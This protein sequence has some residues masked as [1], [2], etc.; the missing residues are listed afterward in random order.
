LDDDTIRSVVDGAEEVKPQPETGTARWPD[1]LDQAALYGIAGEMVSLVA[2]HTESD[3]AALLIQLLVGAGNLFGRYR[4]F[5]VES[6]DHHL[7]LLVV[8]VGPSAKGR[9]G[10]AW[11]WIK[12]ELVEVDPSWGKR[13]QTGLSSGEG[14]IYSVR[15]AGTSN[16]NERRKEK[17]DPGVSDKRALLIQ[18]EFSAVLKVCAREGNTLSDVIRAVWDGGDLQVAT[19]NFPNTATA[20]HVSLIG[21]ISREE[22]TATF[23][24][25]D[26][27]NGFGNRFLWVC[28]KRSNILP[29]GGNLETN[30]LKPII[31]QMRQAYDFAVNNPGEMRFAPEAEA[32]W[33]RIYPDLSGDRTGL[34]GALLS[35]AEAQ[36]RR[37]AC[38][39]TALDS[40]RET[41]TEHLFAALAV[42]EY[43]ERSVAFIFR[44][45]TGNP[46]ADKILAALLKSEG[47]LT[48][49]M[50][51]KLFGGNLPA[52][53]IDQALGALHALGLASKYETKTGGRPEHRWHAKPNKSRR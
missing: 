2:P 29:L 40:A 47:G 33:R 18:P 44:D 27:A 28:A 52:E 30:A 50:I 39:Y 13:I 10:T 12:R 5:K 4:F 31:E 49:T 15:D 6:T 17:P 23:K 11:E 3:P 36:V 14:L 25:T 26:A 7:N 53:R 16:E 34:V 8:L 1:P 51:S 22:L 45:N 32:H 35:R 19:K 41:R 21:H 37:L 20:P 38:I 46:D 48:R 43:V 42:W 24:S 9:K